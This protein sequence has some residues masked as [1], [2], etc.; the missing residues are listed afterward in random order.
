MATLKEIAQAARVSV[1]TVSRVLND[2]PTLSVKNL[3]AM[4][5]SL[6]MWTAAPVKIFFTEIPRGIFGE[7]TV[8][9]NK[10]GVP[11]SAAWI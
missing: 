4:F 5:G 8:L 6:L 9:L 7:K 3:T 2:D 11:T 10:Q 1:A